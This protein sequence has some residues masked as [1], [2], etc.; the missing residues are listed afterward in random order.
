M[1]LRPFLQSN[2]DLFYRVILHEM[3]HSLGLVHNDDKKSV[4]YYKIQNIRELQDL[5][6]A[7]LQNLY[8][9]TS[10]Q[11]AYYKNQLIPNFKSKVRSFHAPYGR[12]C[13]SYNFRKTQ[14]VA[15]TKVQFLENN[16]GLEFFKQ[17]RGWSN[18]S[19]NAKNNKNQCMRIIWNFRSRKQH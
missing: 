8:G 16:A 15:S 3:G 7:H 19:A 18:L 12:S 1:D 2:S 9:P 11:S 4:M 14:T 6:I 17:S 5:D 13:R 10:N